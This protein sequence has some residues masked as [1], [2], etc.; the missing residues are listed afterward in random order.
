LGSPPGLALSYFNALLISPKD[1]TLIILLIA[2]VVSLALSFYKPAKADSLGKSSISNN[3]T[4]ATPT[5]GEG[6]G[7][8]SEQHAGWIEGAAILIAVNSTFFKFLSHPS[9]IGNIVIISISIQPRPFQIK[10][11]K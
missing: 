3:S 11:N 4:G 9:I 8:L 1:V 5:N 10:L 7:G 2:A 6:G